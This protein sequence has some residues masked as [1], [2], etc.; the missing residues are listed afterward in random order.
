MDFLVGDKVIT[1]SNLAATVVKIRCIKN[2]G[3]FV[4]VEYED[5]ERVTCGPYVTRL[6]KLTKQTG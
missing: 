3:N 2:S 4:T 6:W 5:G 1:T